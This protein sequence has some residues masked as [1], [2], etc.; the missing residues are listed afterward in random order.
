[1]SLN[2]PEK[3]NRYSHQGSYECEGVNEKEDG[4]YVWAED[5]DQLLEL[6]KDTLHLLEQHRKSD[7]E[8]RKHRER[9]QKALPIRY[10][11]WHFVEAAADYIERLQSELES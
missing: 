6:Y 8:T 9:L 10:W 11:G 7:T 2:D 4:E 5:Y 3:V 1:M